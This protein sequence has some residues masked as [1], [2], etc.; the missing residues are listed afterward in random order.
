MQNSLGYLF[1]PATGAADGGIAL[2]E[3]YKQAANQYFFST[4]STTPG[5]YTSNGIIAYG[6]PGFFHNSYLH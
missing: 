2:Y 4:S 5:G 6:L 3:Y 1:P